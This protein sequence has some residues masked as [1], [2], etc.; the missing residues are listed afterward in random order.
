[1]AK[2]IRRYVSLWVVLLVFI[3]LVP[4]MPVS[5]SSEA[6][7]GEAYQ[8]L[9]TESHRIAYRIM[10]EGIAGLSPRIE[11][12]GIVDINYSEM[13][14]V[15]R[16]VCVDHPQYFWFLEEG[17]FIYD[18]F[19]GGNYIVSF[20]PKYILNGQPIAVGSQELADAMYTF[21]TK[22]RQIVDGIPVNC[23]TDYEIALYLHDYLAEHVTYTL[24]GEHPSAYAALVLGEAACYG[25]SKAYQC[26]LNAAESVPVPSPATAMT[27]KE[28]WQ[29]MPGIRFGWT[30]SAI[31]W[32]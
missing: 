6:Y 24:E 15:I 2:V 22:V 5:A 16:A 1:M 3:Q 23:T 25:Y 11:F 4:C 8:D 29:D 12:A 31:T 21:H 13:V 30:V 14:K 20:D 10:E 19:S 32:T 27:V 17:R 7:Y 28:D 9:Q 18:E 26:L